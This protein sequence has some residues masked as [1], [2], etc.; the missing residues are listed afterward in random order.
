LKT[1]PQ[2]KSASPFSPD[3]AS[4]EPAGDAEFLRATERIPETIANDP[5]GGDGP[6][7]AD[8]PDPSDLISSELVAG[9]LGPTFQAVFHFAATKRGAHWELADFEKKALVAGWTPILQHLLAKLGNQEQ[10]LLTLAIMSTAAIVAGKAAQD[11]KQAS[12]MASIRT[13]ESEVYS[14]SSASANPGRAPEPENWSE[15]Q[16]A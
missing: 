1:S 7:P 4:D 5:D 10:V 6:R 14:A 13:P 16:A 8:R 3:S 11:I 2:S 12:S 15:E 9:A